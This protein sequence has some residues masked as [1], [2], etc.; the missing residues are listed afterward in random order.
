ME[1][2][3]YAIRYHERRKKIM[4]INQPPVNDDIVKASWEL[5][6][7]NDINQTEQRLIALLR[8]IEQATDLDNLKIRIRNI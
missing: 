4:A 2:I 5:Q 1:S 3:W 7:T 8:A 6:V